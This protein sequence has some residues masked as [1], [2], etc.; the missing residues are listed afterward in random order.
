MK[1]ETT[2][3]R[4]VTLYPSQWKLVES[5]AAESGNP[6]NTSAGLRALIAEY[7]RLKDNS[8]ADESVD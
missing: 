3:A 8:T 2:E 7:E 1:Q 4:H 5:K 6:G